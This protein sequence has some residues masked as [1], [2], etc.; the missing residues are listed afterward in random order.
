LIDLL[1]QEVDA[2]HAWFDEE[3]RKGVMDARTDEPQ[4]A[5]ILERPAPDEDGDY[6]ASSDWPVYFRWS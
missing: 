3:V 1:Q 5:R 4:V 6:P 2:L